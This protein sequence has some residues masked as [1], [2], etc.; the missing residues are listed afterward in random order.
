M[1]KTAVLTGIQA[2]DYREAPLPCIAHD[3]EVLL[4]VAAVG[5]CGSDVHYYASGRIGSQVVKYPFI[6]GHE[7]SAVVEKIGR[8]VTR[9]RVGDRVAVE[10]AIS[11]WTCDQCLQGRP[12][13]CR[14][15]RFLGCPG[16]ANGCLSEFIV[17]PEDCCYPIPPSMTFEQAAISEPLSIGVYAVTLAEIMP[18]A[19][20]GILGSGPI[21]LSV[22]LAAREAGATAVYMTDRRDARIRVALSAGATWAGNPDRE[23]VVGAIVSAEPLLLD[24]VVECCGRQEAVDQAVTL[25][26]P[27]GKLMMV[28]IPEAD[29]ISLPIDMARRKEISFQNVRRQNHCLQSALNLIANNR[30]NV[31]FM[32]THRFP[33][34]ETKEAFALVHEYRDGVVKA[35][36]SI[37][38][39]NS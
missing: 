37:H 20:I 14:N 34:S 19:R 21:G 22:L 25:L 24:V 11:C 33:F 36:V 28:G 4:R 39:G 10:P 9:V 6:V 1:M 26:K 35:M 30:V 18:G 16:Q 12:H 31:D 27:G 3:Y 38:G 15:L 5:V 32:V 13:T 29:R 23:D 2:M 17:M 8:S 7:C